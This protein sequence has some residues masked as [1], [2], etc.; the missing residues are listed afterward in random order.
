MTADHH[1]ALSQLER[2]CRAAFLGVGADQATAEAATRAMLHGTRFGVD[3]HGVRLLPHYLTALEGGRLNRNPELRCVGGFGAVEVWDADNAQGALGAYRGM[4]RAVDLARQFGLGAVAIRNNSHFG[5]A[6][7][8]ALAAAEAGFIGIT[9]CNSDSF[10]RLHDG[11]MRFHGT[12]PIA[13][14]VPVQGGDPWFLDMATSAVPYN[15]VQLYRSLGVALPQSVASDVQGNDTT[16][17]EQ[18]DMLAPLGG[19]FG[20]KGAALAGV[21]EIFSA[22]LTGMRLSFDILPMGGP[23]FST[24][25]GM[26]AF[27]LALNPDA[28]LDRAQFD[29]G[30]RRYV[31]VLRGSPA[32]A[33]CRVMAPGD[34]EWDVARARDRAGVILDPATAEAFAKIAARLGIAPPA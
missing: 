11:A 34:R 7:A 1:I 32:R 3:S 6:G 22:V 28:F 9:F 18:A 31:E 20:F 13:V 19:E 2:F 25:R 23:D 29:A 17:P 8:Y 24:P 15:R 33:D 26:G 4:E 10:V 14:A 21:A 12:N 16:D 27:V 5:P 30:M